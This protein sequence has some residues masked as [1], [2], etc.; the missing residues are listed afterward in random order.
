VNNLGILF[1][2]PLFT[3]SGLHRQHHLWNSRTRYTKI[4][5]T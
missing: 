2:D 1:P 5:H 3:S 4:S